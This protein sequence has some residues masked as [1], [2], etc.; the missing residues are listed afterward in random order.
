MRSWHKQQARP[1]APRAR[2]RRGEGRRRGLPAARAGLGPE[3]D[4]GALESTR[5]ATAAAARRF[6]PQQG[7]SL[8]HEHPALDSA[9]PRLHRDARLEP[10]RLQQPTP[11]RWW[12][13]GQGAGGLGG[14]PGRARGARQRSGVPALA[15]QVWHPPLPPEH[16]GGEQS[17]LPARRDGLLLLRPPSALDA[18]QVPQEDPQLRVRLR[19]DL[20]RER[21]QGGPR[22]CEV[23]LA[24]GARTAAAR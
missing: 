5:G 1:Q 8:G 15:G 22:R 20:Q 19:F 9:Q 13:Q 12:T 11:E 14:H 21:G 23:G 24:V 16:R 6:R 18:G 3:E 17:A 7:R 4:R 10:A 2:A